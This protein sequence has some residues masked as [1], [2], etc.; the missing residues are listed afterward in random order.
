MEKHSSRGLAFADYDNDG[1]VEALVNNQNEP[2]I[3]AAA[4]VKSL[5]GESLD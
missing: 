5:A 3:A 2:P 4:G 1:S